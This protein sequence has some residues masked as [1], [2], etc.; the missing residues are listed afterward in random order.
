MKR[1]LLLA[2]VLGIFPKVASADADSDDVQTDDLSDG[3]AKAALPLKLAD[4][5][6]F[7]V[8]ASPAFAKAR[9]DRQIAVGAL[10]ATASEQAWIVT[11]KLSADR[12]AVADKVE[13]DPMAQVA[14]DK[15]DTSV[16]VKTKFS[17]GASISFEVSLDHS[18]TEYN[19]SAINGFLTNTAANMTGGT[20]QTQYEYQDGNTFTTK[21][22]FI[23]PLL[24]GMGSDVAL[25]KKH[26]AEIDLMT[27]TVK[28]QEAAEEAVY[29]LVNSYW[30]LANTAYEVDIRAES[31]ALAEKQAEITHAELRVGTTPATSINSI[32]YELAVRRE[33]LVKAQLDLEKKSLDL[34]R[35]AGLEL[36]QR[37]ILLK[38]AETFEI[39]EDAVD[40]K[41]A[42]AR[43][44]KWNRKAAEI[45][46]QRKQAD[47]DVAVTDNMMLPQLDIGVSGALIGYGGGAEGQQGSTGLGDALSGLSSGFE[48]MGNI[49]VSFE[50]GG[51]AKAAHQAALARRHKLDIERA[52]LERTTDT[53]VVAAIHDIA[54]ARERVQLANQSI[55]VA[56]E[57]L[58]AEHAMYNMGK[59]ENAKIMQKQSQTIEARI[60]LGRAVADYHIYVA[61]L[62]SL[63]GTLLGQFGIDVRPPQAN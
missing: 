15:I 29:D 5:I 25:Q 8:K 2:A 16:E 1:C 31:L 41:E 19:I 45:A 42:L 63:N 55:A 7:A 3:E 24:R 27:A 20:D 10:G 51:G 18:V 49:T 26:K 14:A 4:L 39:G 58:R 12:S 54:G 28:G 48:V 6:N 13:V 43:S 22:S 59:G 33:A 57:N 40:T 37:D 60:R 56:E 17:N 53:Q 21:V 38:P 30:E 9:V 62:R 11:A 36:S 50:I 52:D 44:R 23:Q 61:K 34:R 35:K 46:L 47:I 32:N